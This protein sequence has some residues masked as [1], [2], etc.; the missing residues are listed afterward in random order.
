[1]KKMVAVL[2]ILTMLLSL[3]ACS[4]VEET[5]SKIL[6]VHITAGKIEPGMTA[7]DVFVEV[8]IDNQPVACRVKLTGFVWD[9]YWEMAEDE[10]VTEDFSVRLD[11]FY[12]LPKGYDVENINVTMECEGGQYDGTGSISVD[13]DGNI[14]AWSRA[15]YGEEPEPPENELKEDSKLETEESA[16]KTEESTSKLEE[17]IPETEESIPMIEETIPTI[18][19]STPAI[20]ESIPTTES[21]TPPIEHTHNWTELPGPGILSCTVDGV[22]T[23]QCDCGE[24]KT[25]IIPAPGHDLNE[26]SA[27]SATCTRDGSKSTTCKYCNAGFSVEVPATGHNWLEWVYK[28]GRVHVHTCAVCG[29]EEEENHTIPENSVTC[30]GCGVDIIN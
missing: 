30:T 25:E 28:T 8:T 11:I 14:E 19:E 12:S 16:S 18:E 23:F 24:T 5:S 2:L 4:A 15:F 7:K 9:G 17:S 10:Q 1:M 27:S 20:E 26:W 3:C 21:E 13:K 6:E 29:A 22:K